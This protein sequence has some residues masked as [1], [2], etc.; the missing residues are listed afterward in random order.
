MYRCTVS[1]RDRLLLNHESLLSTVEPRFELPAELYSRQVLDDEE[2]STLC[3][4]SGVYAGCDYLL[5]VIPQKSIETNE[6][7]LVSL[8]A[9]EQSHVATFIR[10]EGGEYRHCCTN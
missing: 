2:Y 4:Q 5:N 1:L 6:Q 10:Q 7:F 8:T 9:A 3:E